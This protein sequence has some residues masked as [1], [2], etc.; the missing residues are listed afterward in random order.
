MPT[1]YPK[2][3][4]ILST[5]NGEKYIR[6]L[7]I[8]LFN[9]TYPHIEI[10]IRDD[11]SIDNTVNIINSFSREKR[12]IHLTLGENI[13]VPSS[14]HK[15]LNCKGKKD[16]LYA[17]CDQD[18]IWKPEKVS[19]AVSKITARHQPENVLYFSRLEYVDEHLNHL[20]LSLTPHHI[21][22]SNA[23]VENIAIG[24]TIVFGSAIK[25]LILQ[26]NPHDMMMHDWWAYLTASTFGDVI[27]DNQ[28]SILYRQHGNSVTGWEP[29]LKKIITRAHALFSRLRNNKK[30]GFQ[31][32]N[33]ATRF[34]KTYPHTPKDITSIVNKLIEL[35]NKGTFL[36]RLIYL[37]KLEVTRTDKI[38]NI[39][40]RLIILCGWH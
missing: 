5:Y 14:F 33:Q 11:G 29:R 40:L 19:R 31:S 7:L 2:V 27:Y 8:S 35:R 37:S 34:I 30:T 17:F 15:T 32:L 38:E 22:I 18:D 3:H 20:G 9:Q 13:G 16:D 24:C 36:K 23:I 12:K 39:F 28:S 10:H 4:I 1:K 21:G 26:A 6:E 25:Q